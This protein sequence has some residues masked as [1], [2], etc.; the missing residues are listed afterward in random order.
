MVMLSLVCSLGVGDDKF[1]VGSLEQAQQ[2]SEETKK[3][4]LLIFGAEYCIYCEKLKR[5]ILARDLPE[6]D[7][8]IICY[9]DTEKQP[10][11]KLKYGV[12][13]I[14]DSRII[15]GNKEKSKLI[16]FNS[17]QYKGWAKTND[18]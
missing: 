11:Y 2:L 14:P 18:K 1:I 4:L 5:A 9:I 13:A 6:T 3:P 16:G 10:E 8:Y 17:R 12:S 7:P 15:V